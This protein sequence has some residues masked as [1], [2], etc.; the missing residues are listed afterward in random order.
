MLGSKKDNICSKM[1]NYKVGQNENM[2][3]V[4][5]NFNKILTDFIEVLISVIGL[6]N[7]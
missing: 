1:R 3:I 6:C 2:L 4:T 5:V 7:Q